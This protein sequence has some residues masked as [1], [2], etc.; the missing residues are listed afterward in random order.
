[1]VVVAWLQDRPRLNLITTWRAVN[2]ITIGGSDVRN[3]VGGKY[4]ET[5]V[6]INVTSSEIH[7]VTTFDNNTIYRSKNE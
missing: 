5:I 4:A 1:V 2:L 7:I 3:I 6:I